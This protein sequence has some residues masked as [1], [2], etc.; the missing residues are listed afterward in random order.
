[1]PGLLSIGGVQKNLN[2]KSTPPPKKKSRFEIFWARHKHWSKNLKSQEIAIRLFLSS[3]H[4]SVFSLGVSPMSCQPQ[5]F[6]P[7]EVLCLD[8]FIVALSQACEGGRKLWYVSSLEL[9]L[10]SVDFCRACR[11]V[12]IWHVRVG[13]V[14][15]PSLWSSPK[16]PTTASHV[17]SSEARN[18]S[19]VPVLRALRLA[20]NLP[21]DLLLQSAATEWW[22]WSLQE[23]SVGPELNKSIVGAVWPAPLRQ[24]S[25]G[26]SFNKPI[27][28]V[29]AGFP[30]AAIARA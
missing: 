7:G 12:P 11:S 14:T 30:A 19:R 9:Q 6:S 4:M 26:H 5:C 18:Y 3:L 20:W 8:A 27:V 22:A 15:P 2:L 21:L 23:L 16:L 28:G 25:F 17:L 13:Q 1:M 24:L 29:V 10:L